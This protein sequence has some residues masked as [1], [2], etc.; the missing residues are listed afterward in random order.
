M[1]NR[2]TNRR[3][4]KAGF[5]R[6]HMTYN[7]MLWW[8]RMYKKFAAFFLYFEAKLTQFYWFF[9]QSNIRVSD[10]FLQKPPDHGT[11]L[12]FVGP[13]SGIFTCC[14]PAMTTRLD[15]LAVLGLA[16]HWDLILWQNPCFDSKDY[17]VYL[18]TLLWLSQ[19][20]ANFS[21]FGVYRRSLWH[22]LAIFWPRPNLLIISEWSRTKYYCSR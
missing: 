9:H 7:D 13:I 21:P 5:S 11:K 6:V 4:D 8:F 16:F 14:K 2:P 20:W 19:F 22:P 18:L 1:T 10:E 17:H 3:A 15:F 12:V